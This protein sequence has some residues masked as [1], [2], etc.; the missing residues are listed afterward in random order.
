MS[1]DEARAKLRAADESKAVNTP[2]NRAERA[3][4]KKEGAT[5]AARPDVNRYL[6]DLMAEAA[7]RSAN[8][9]EGFDPKSADAKIADMFAQ[10]MMAN[11]KNLDP[12]RTADVAKA[13]VD[14]ERPK[15]AKEIDQGVYNDN[16]RALS[17]LQVALVESIKSL[18]R[19]VPIRLQ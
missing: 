8:G 16:T 3:A 4:V 17:Q 9:Q 13:A 10:R 1:E 5:L 19:G 7:A 14:R 2:E 6:D 12:L 11:N 15:V 18:S